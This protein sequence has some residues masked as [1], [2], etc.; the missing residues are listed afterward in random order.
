ML[1]RAL[2]AASRVLRRASTAFARAADEVDLL[3]LDVFGLDVDGI[4]ELVDR[5][6]PVQATPAR[7]TPEAAELLA[8]PPAAPAPP[9]EA[10]LEG[11]LEARRRGAPR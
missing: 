6:Q 9:A 10:P 5:L 4:D 7:V 11:S 3:E 8:T 1:R 2:S